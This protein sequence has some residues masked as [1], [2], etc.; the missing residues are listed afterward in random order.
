[1]K[2]QEQFH[3]QVFNSITILSGVLIMIALNP[4]GRLVPTMT[5]HDYSRI[6]DYLMIIAFCLGTISILYGWFL[7]FVRFKTKGEPRLYTT[8]LS[9]KLASILGVF[10]YLVV[11]IVFM[12]IL[13]LYL[14]ASEVI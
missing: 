13:M 6:V 8:L 10:F 4:L 11:L 9:S 3:R 14:I 1:M 2:N 7:V 12:L 5:E